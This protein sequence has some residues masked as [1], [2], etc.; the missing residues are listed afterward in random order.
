MLHM[1]L[2]FL[3]FPHILGRRGRERMVVGFTTCAIGAFH[4]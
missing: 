4:H 2:E 3:C 1:S